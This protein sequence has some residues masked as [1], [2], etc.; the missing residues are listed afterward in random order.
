M[1]RSMNTSRMILALLV[2]FA[3]QACGGGDAEEDE[4]PPPD[5]PVTCTPQDCNKPG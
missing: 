2:C 5:E 4:Q 1:L 3:L